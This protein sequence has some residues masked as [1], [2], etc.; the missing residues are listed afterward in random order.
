MTKKTEP[1]KELFSLPQELLELG[2]EYNSY[3]FNYEF[4]RDGVR[5]QI[6]ALSIGEL[7]CNEKKAKQLVE[8]LTKTCK[9]FRELTF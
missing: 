3:S 4:M 8:H 6:S 9:L 2:F 1:K 5:I 7:M